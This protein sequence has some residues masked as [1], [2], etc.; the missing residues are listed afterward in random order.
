MMQPGSMQNEDKLGE[1]TKWIFLPLL[2]MWGVLS[3]LN[4]S[5]KK[6]KKKFKTENAINIYHAATTRNTN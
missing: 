2:G 5:R 6:K 3:K 1:K 4:E